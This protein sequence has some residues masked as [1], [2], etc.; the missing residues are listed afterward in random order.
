MYF[1]KVVDT[2]DTHETKSQNMG[3]YDT[4]G[5][6]SKWLP[7]QHGKVP[8]NS[9]ACQP[10]R[11]REIGARPG[12]KGE[13]REASPRGDQCQQMLIEALE[14]HGIPVNFVSNE[15]GELVAWRHP[16]KLDDEVMRF[17]D[18]PR[19]VGSTV[20]K[21]CGCWS[22][23]K[24]RLRAARL[25]LAALVACDKEEVALAP[26]ADGAWGTLLHC[27]PGSVLAAPGSW[28]GN[29]H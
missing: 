13:G 26:T 6:R 18:Q 11:R 7:G 10:D 1:S 22:T 23:V 12:A 28:Q 17:H 20:K 3:T 8:L 5:T 4:P 29:F 19:G 15:S 25:A 27:V 16:E 2:Y 14:S 21:S 9:R 24:K